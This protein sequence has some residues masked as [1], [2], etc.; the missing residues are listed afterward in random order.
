MAKRGS[1]RG[2]SKSAKGA[3][4]GD[5]RKRFLDASLPSPKD[6]AWRFTHPELLFD[7]RTRR[8][9]EQPPTEGNGRA[10]PSLPELGFP[11]LADDAVPSAETA[12]L[13]DGVTFE[14]LPSRE[15][16]FM[17]SADM[18]P[19]KF[20]LLIDARA[21]NPIA[22]TVAGDAQL[23]SPLLLR[24]S[25]PSGA[26]KAAVGA[27]DL[28]ES[29]SAQLV[30]WLDGGSDGGRYFGRHLV[31]LASGAKLSAVIVQA[32]D[33]SAR[34]LQRLR[35]QLA[36]AARLRLLL[37]N[38]GAEVARQELHLDI[39]GSQA[40]AEVRGFALARG[41]QR[42]DLHS[43]AVH[44]APQA[45]SR[46]R[47][48]QVLLDESRAVFDGMVQ[49]LAGM[50][51][52]DAYQECHTLLLS[53]QARVHAIPRLEIATHDVRCGHGA[54]VKRL[55][56]AEVFYLR[57]RGLREPAAKWLLT[58]GFLKEVIAGPEPA[59]LTEHLDQMLDARLAEHIGR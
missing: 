24:S 49:V 19:D 53:E 58:G 2:K 59:A 45:E 17:E 56:P 12:P 51:G 40:E 20:D 16:P 28:K 34:L 27:I 10:L 8:L 9:V 29:A 44:R 35:I 18:P 15:V 23:P 57:S 41:K 6:E 3:A 31:K 54:T 36:E 32:A 48:K 7:E 37:V 33:G 47:Y 21:L 55:S 43:T 38:L 30:L 46:L 50:H 52:T 22:L 4:E 11:V 39:V 26:L 25:L 13:P 5:A 14:A 1:T 42:R